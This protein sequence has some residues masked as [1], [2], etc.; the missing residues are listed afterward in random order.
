MFDF[1]NPGYEIIDAHVHPF[2]C[3]NSLEYTDF[4]GADMDDNFIL[5]LK[6]A[7][8]SRAAGSVIKRYPAN[9]FTWEV[10]HNFNLKAL[11]S[12]DRYD[13]YIIPG[14]CVHPWF[15][16]ESLEEV[17]YMYHKEN[18]RLIG[19]LV[20]HMCHCRRYAV[21]ELDP[22]WDFA[23][24]HGMV[25]NIH[26]THLDDM[27]LLMKKFPDL[28]LIIAHPTAQP[29][30]YEARMRFVAKYPNAALD[31]SGSGPNTWGMLRRG[32]NWAGKEKLI[33]GTDFPLRN[34]GMYVAGVLYERLSDDENA[35]IF[36]GNFKRLM[37]L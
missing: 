20:S 35:A 18:V 36:A 34:P 29:A 6:G 2:S 3:Y 4:G 25:V 13:N 16:K 21:P 33:F 12:R 8:I 26:I 11:E 24:A 10:C 15:P 14:I 28:K 32:I 23:Q 1:A 17:D 5:A 27:R 22:V 31:I 7:G 37:G 19:E 9:E 30:E